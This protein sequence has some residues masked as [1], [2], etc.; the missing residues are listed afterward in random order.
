[1]SCMWTPKVLLILILYV[2]FGL[3]Q[4]G[5]LNFNTHIFICE[6]IKTVCQGGADVTMCFQIIY[7]H[8][9]MQPVDR[10]LIST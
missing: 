5:M 3:M 6:M 10:W 7:I 2:I 9:E 8:F 1:M 4:N